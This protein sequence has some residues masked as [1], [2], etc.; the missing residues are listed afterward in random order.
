MH[1]T[2]KLAMHEDPEQT[3]NSAVARRYS[4]TVS[5]L[6]EASLL[7][8]GRAVFAERDPH[9]TPSDDGDPYDDDFLTSVADRR[10]QMK[11]QIARGEDAVIAVLRCT[12]DIRQIVIEEFA[13]QSANSWAV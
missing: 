13:R 6:L 2:W 1:L 4:L 10:D 5:T 11:E 3:R 9:F 7:R 12:E 8:L